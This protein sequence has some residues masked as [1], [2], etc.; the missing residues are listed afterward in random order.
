MRRVINELTT[1]LL[2]VGGAGLVGWGLY[3]IYWPLAP[4][5][6]GLALVGLGVRRLWA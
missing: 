2:V 5:V 3:N 1:D 4:I 6:L